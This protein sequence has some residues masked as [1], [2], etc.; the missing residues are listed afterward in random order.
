M[1]TARLALFT[2]QLEGLHYGSVVDREEDGLL[3]RAVFVAVPLPERDNESVPLL[4]FQVALPDG[5][6]APSAEDMVERR[7]CVAVGLGAYS[8]TEALDFAG[9]GRQGTSP[10]RG[11]DVADQMSVERI[12]FVFLESL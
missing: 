9:H 7:A 4:P 11:I 2:I 3:S 10:G 1:S 5:R 12:S 6:P 8:R